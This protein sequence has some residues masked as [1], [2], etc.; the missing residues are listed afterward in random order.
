MTPEQIARVR[1]SVAIRQGIQLR[2]Y[3]LGLRASRPACGACHKHPAKPGE[4]FCYQCQ[5]RF[6]AIDRQSDSVSGIRADMTRLGVPMGALTGFDREVGSNIS[7]DNTNWHG[8]VER[9]TEDFYSLAI[10]ND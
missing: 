3:S 7:A 9:A 1:G 8:N 6:D 10:D 4:K 5:L 2:N